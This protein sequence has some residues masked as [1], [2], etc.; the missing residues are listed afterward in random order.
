MPYHFISGL[1]RSGSTLLASILAQ[2]P[3]FRA[4]IMSPIG[5]VVTDAITAMGPSN[6][7]S[8]IITTE[9]RARMIRGIFAGF[10]HDIVWEA[11]DFHTVVFDN[12]RRWCANLA[13]ID[14]VFPDSKVI[15]CV[16]D[17]PDIVDSFERVFRLNPLLP[18]VIYG[19]TANFTVFN[20]VRSVLG[21]EAVL[22]FALNAFRDAFYGA[23]RKKL[24]IV[25]YV[26][27]C[28][29]PAGV[30]TELHA[31]IDEA[32]FKYR[33]DK[34]EAVKGAAEFDRKLGTPGLH[35]LKSQVILDPP[36]RTLPPEIVKSLPLPFWRVSEAVRKPR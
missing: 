36:Q 16:R 15:C 21:D 11:G 33:F 17:I 7:A 20:R 35:D 34:I 29:R 31:A 28:T 8:D 9:Q 13:M 4:S 18:S 26:D 25:E 1:P 12:N 10:Y 32:P 2:N 14:A 6:E 30:M 24:F 3:N 23:F 27:L 19:G 5:Q 22:G